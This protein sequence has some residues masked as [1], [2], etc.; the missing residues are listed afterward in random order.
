MQEEKRTQRAAKAATTAKKVRRGDGHPE[1]F[2][3]S[4][5][6]FKDLAEVVEM[7]LFEE[8]QMSKQT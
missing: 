3:E 7:E 5:E 6:E 1:D 2:I 4:C 8:T